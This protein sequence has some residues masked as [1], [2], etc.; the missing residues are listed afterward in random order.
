[1]GRSHGGGSPPALPG[2]H[3]THIRPAESPLD[4]DAATEMANAIAK[5]EEKAR[6]AAAGAPPKSG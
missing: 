1:M 2:R 6:K 4:S 5:Y 3:P